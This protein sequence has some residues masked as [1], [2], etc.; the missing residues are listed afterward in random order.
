M[1]A[2]S[3]RFS[4]CLISCTLQKAQ[5]I[6]A[7]DYKAPNRPENYARSHYQ[8]ASAL[9]NATNSMEIFFQLILWEDFAIGQ[10][11]S[12]QFDQ[13]QCLYGENTGA[14]CKGWEVVSI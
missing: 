13:V 9:H 11:A 12:D 3:L 4:L 7:N 8:Y 10:K 1:R 5:S 6:T 14:P 2:A